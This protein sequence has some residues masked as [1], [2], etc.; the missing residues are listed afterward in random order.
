[1]RDAASQGDLAAEESSY[2]QPF[3][4][5]FFWKDPRSKR[6]WQQLT[7]IFELHC[8]VPRPRLAGMQTPLL[9]I[10]TAGGGRQR[11]RLLARRCMLS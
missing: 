7:R 6:V 5:T 1:M 11:H 8:P 4:G 2:N 3:A 9:R 10:H